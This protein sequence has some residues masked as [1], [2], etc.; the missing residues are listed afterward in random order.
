MVGDWGRAGKEKIASLAESERKRL[1]KKYGMK[2]PL[3]VMRLPRE[4]LES[5][6]GIGEYFNPDEGAEI[7]EDFHDI[8]S[9]L[10][11]RGADL[12]TEEQ[13]AI[14]GWVWSKSISPGFVRRL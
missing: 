10:R 5:K 9:G 7:M 13:E 14:R 3:P 1:M 4:L 11:K 2:K 8:L 6:N 12:T